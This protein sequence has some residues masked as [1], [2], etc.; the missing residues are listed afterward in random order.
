[1][2]NN[3]S[4]NNVLLT[5]FTN[6]NGAAGYLRGKIPG[7]V[8]YLNN[9]FLTR[10]DIQRIQTAEILSEKILS[11]TDFSELIPLRSEVA[12]LEIKRLLSYKKQTDHTAHTVYLFLLGIWVY[13][14]NK[15]IQG[16]IDE[17]I[18]SKKR[19]KMFIFQ[20]TFAS[21]LHDIGY[22]FYEYKQT[23]NDDSWK[24]YDK[25]FEDENIIKSAGNISEQN[26]G[27]FQKIVDKFNEFK[28]I[29]HTETSSP[30]EL[31]NQLSNIPWLS[32]LDLKSLNGLEV[33]ELETRVGDGLTTFSTKMATEGYDGK[34]PVVDH[35]IASSLMLLKYSSM[36]YWLYKEAEKYEE[37]F[38]ELTVNFKY[39]IEVLKK[40]VIPACSAVAYHNMPNVSFELSQHPLL[41]LAVLCDELQVWDRFLSGQEHIDNWKDVEHCMSEQITAEIIC[42]P[43]G[44]NQIHFLTTKN[45]KEKI[46]KTMNSRLVGWQRFVQLSIR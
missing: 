19:L 45:Q 40:H 9:F 22:L 35:G 13:D 2:R 4:I 38:A 43:V 36:W 26:K 5:H 17:S 18:K 41:Y 20:W 34:T 11:L 42:D 23:E 32:E 1:M 30:I 27:S 37:L 3:Q 16:S 7:I 12:T 29:S 46:T 8:N 44:E 21:L 15:E 33:M 6:G 39:P 14:N 24:L 31:V 10:S 28:S 25:M